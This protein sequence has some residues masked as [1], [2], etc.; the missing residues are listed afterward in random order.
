MI[1][2]GKWKHDILTTF[3]TWNTKEGHLHRSPRQS[4]LSVRQ[5]MFCFALI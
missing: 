3:P 2:S 5:V 1:W 4:S